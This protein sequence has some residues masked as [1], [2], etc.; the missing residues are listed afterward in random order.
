M[1]LAK[2]HITHILRQSGIVAET[3]QAD[4]WVRVVAEIDQYVKARHALLT[5]GFY[6]G[7]CQIHSDG[8]RSMLIGQLLID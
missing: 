1:R 5:Q 2:K 6:L 8:R 7:D 4:E 3:H